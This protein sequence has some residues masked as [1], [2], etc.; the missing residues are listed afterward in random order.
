MQVLRCPGW[1]NTNGDV[2]KWT[3]WNRVEEVKQKDSGI[4]PTWQLL[5]GNKRL[6]LQVP[7]TLK[8]PP[9]PLLIQ[10]GTSK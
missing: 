2:E 9:L 1:S 6:K 7:M 8:L 3:N 4:D 5:L 10:Y